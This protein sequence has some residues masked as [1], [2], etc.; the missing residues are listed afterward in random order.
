MQRSLWT[1][2]FRRTSRPAVGDSRLVI[3]LAA[4]GVRGLRPLRYE[5]RV[6]RNRF[7]ALV[8]FLLVVLLGILS[9]FLHNH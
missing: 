5:K 2:I 7:V 3:Y 6:A 1:P 4:G 8:I 9:I